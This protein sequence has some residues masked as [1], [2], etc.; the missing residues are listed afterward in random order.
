MPSKKWTG[1]RKTS[2]A[3]S[4]PIRD[5]ARQSFNMPNALRLLASCILAVTPAAAADIAAFE[6]VSVKPSALATQG[7]TLEPS[8]GGR[9]TVSNLSLEGLICAAWKIQPWQL[10]GAPAW[11]RA[12]RW[13]IAAKADGDPDHQEVLVLLQGLLKDRFRVVLHWETK[14]MTGFTLS[15]R[16]GA[17]PGSNIHAVEETECAERSHKRTS[18]MCG[19]VMV[20]VDDQNFND[21]RFVL[22]LFG[23]PMPQLRNLL[24]N[25]LEGP[26]ADQTGMDGR[27]DMKIRWSP[28]PQPDQDSGPSIF[29]AV[30]EQLGLKLESR[31][32]PADLLVV[33]HAE[34]PAE[35]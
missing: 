31:K 29:T 11:A 25:R 15:A 5:L 2:P 17:K 6:V 14:E 12:E 34:R 20:K 21:K 4:Q 26:V 16:P 9:M 1:R 24:S 33:D 10:R 7:G 27:F 22:E 32:V 30:Q 28:N 3:F 23:A 18:D 35:N 19:N 8:P 13:N